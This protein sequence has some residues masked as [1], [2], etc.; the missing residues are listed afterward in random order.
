M[1]A[2]GLDVERF[3]TAVMPSRCELLWCRDYAQQTAV[4][5]RGRSNC[6]RVFLA[7]EHAAARIGK[8][9]LHAAGSDALL[10]R[11]RA[12]RDVFVIVRL[13]EGDDLDVCGF[14]GCAV[15]GKLE[16]KQNQLV[17]V[18]HDRGVAVVAQPCD[19]AEARD[20]DLVATAVEGSL[21]ERD[22]AAMDDAKRYVLGICSLRD[23]GAREHRTDHEGGGVRP[24]EGHTAV[25]PRPRRGWLRPGRPFC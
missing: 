21:G 10:E 2:V 4:G 9:L 14:F 12:G 19:A 3:K 25:L 16:R 20:L 7:D 8:P 1:Q 13:R 17:A 6:W 5:Q 11:F 18:V 22:R 24:N 23:R 15:S